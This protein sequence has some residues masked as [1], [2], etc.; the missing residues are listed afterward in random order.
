MREIEETFR[1]NGIVFFL[2]KGP[3]VAQYYPVPAL[4]TMGDLDIVIHREDR[5]RA[6][7]ILLQ[8]G[9]A[10]TSHLEDREWQ[11]FRNDLEY[12]LHDHLVYRET[13]NREK[14]EAFFN[15]F[16]LFVKE[17][18]L[19][20]GFHFL[21][22]LLH[23]RKH[24]M[25]N[26]AGFRM[27][28]DLALTGM[29]ESE[30]N[31]PWIREKLE[32]LELLPFAQVCAGFIHRWFGVVLPLEEKLPDH[33][34]YEAATEAVLANGVFG[35]DNAE[36]RVNSTANIARQMGYWRLELVRRTLRLV[37]PPYH[38]MLKSRYGGFVENR[39]WLLPAAWVYRLFRASG[40][41]LRGQRD[42]PFH[43]VSGEQVRQR[44]EYL[45]Q[46]GL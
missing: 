32:E 44:D 9:F 41:I 46:W 18:K 39:K 38:M 31:W 17:G 15:D 25:N 8:L 2:I 26:G 23:L 33:A 37:F 14:L 22:L 30:L 16:W 3:V 5:D 24:L 43:H 45:R 4:R 19:D 10:N 11:Y 20:A 7:E 36:N 21:F 6:H 35:F 28:M 34:F 12:E 42:L 1:E 27:F 29:K 13:V 40:P